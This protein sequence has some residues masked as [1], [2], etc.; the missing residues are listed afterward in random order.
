[1]DVDIFVCL[2][3]SPVALRHMHEDRAPFRHQVMST[4]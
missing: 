2:F 3:V 1:L 4:F